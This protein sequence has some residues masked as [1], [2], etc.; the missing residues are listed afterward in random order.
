MTDHF[1]QRLRDTARAVPTPEAPRDLIARVL[2]ERAAGARIRLPDDSVK[3]RLSRGRIVAVLATTIGVAAMATV[4]VSHRPS[5]SPLPAD[6]TISSA[7][8]FFVSTALA[9]EV[10]GT[11]SIPAVTGV[12]GTRI[13]PRRYDYRIQYVK[14]NGDVTPDGGGSLTVSAATMDGGPAW[15]M[16]L[17]GQQ[18]EENGQRR[19]MAESLLVRRRSLEP[20]TRTVHVRPYRRYSGI[21]IAQRFVGDSVLGEMRTDGGV[22][23]P[24]ARQL[25][26]QFGPY[27]SDAIA[28][29]GLVG[30][31]LS[32]DWSGRLSVPGWAVVPTDVFYPVT[33]RVV[34]EERLSTAAGSFDCWKLSV[35]AGR[36]RRV[37]WVR[38]SDGLALRSYDEVATPKG[39]RQ[40]DL[41]NP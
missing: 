1:E 18:T 38:K 35:V 14:P 40:Y 12:D 41:L 10:A 37:Q 16:V 4:F 39:H 17:D 29:L 15:R 2:A 25:P 13:V 7:G 23:R 8:G 19:T 28:P 5:R 30:V 32:R 27:V 9:G 26:A 36:E 6:E 11:L 3:P 21:D 20:L 31:P 33:L 34:G 24:I 22:H